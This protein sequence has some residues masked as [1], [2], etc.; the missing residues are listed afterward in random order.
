[1]MEGNI[2]EKHLFIESVLNDM[3]ARVANQTRTCD[4][5]SVYNAN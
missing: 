1:M 3:T 4:K 5:I 2:K